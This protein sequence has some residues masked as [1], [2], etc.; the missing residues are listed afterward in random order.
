[1]LA[2][3]GY[4]D[5]SGDFFITI[6]TDKC[7]GCGDCIKVCPAKVLEMITDESD[8][9]REIP[10]VAVTGEHRKKIKYSCSPCKG[11]QHKSASDLPCVKACSPGAIAHSW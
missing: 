4:N 1:M 10:V 8:P 7:T 3:Y 6:D 9:F 5:G 11:V 2:N